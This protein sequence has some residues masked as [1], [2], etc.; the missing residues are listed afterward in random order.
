MV[1]GGDLGTTALIAMFLVP[2][3]SAVKRPS[4]SSKVNFAVS[5]VA[6]A[7]AAV[8]GIAIDNQGK[9]FRELVPQ[10]S[11]AFATTQVVYQLYFGDTSLNAKLTSIGGE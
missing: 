9:T 11:T 3:V 5:M 10:F 8:A 4:W 2:V 1:D 6:A 7:I